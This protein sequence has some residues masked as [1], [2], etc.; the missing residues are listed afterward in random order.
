MDKAKNILS[1]FVDTYKKW[2]D[3]RAIRMAAALSY[4]GLFSVAPLVFLLTTVI[5]ALV[6]RS[7]GQAVSTDDVVQLLEGIFG[8]ELAAYVLTHQR[9]APSPSARGKKRDARSL[10]ALFRKDCMAAGIHPE[11]APDRLD[12]HDFR[13]TFLTN[14][15]ANALEA[16]P[17]LHTERRLVG[18]VG[19]T[20]GAAG[21]FLRRAAATMPSPKGPAP[22][23]TTTWSRS[24]SPR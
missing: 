9:E 1:I 8:P 21:G 24:M 17:A 11:N 19:T 20:A 4:Y 15:V 10:L 5:G 14:L 13:G 2:N 23:I 22:A 16:M 18:T 6:E 7:I 12:G 3:D